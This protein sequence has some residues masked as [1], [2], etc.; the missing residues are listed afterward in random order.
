MSRIN[1]IAPSAPHPDNLLVVEKL[2]MVADLLEAQSASVFRVRAY[3]A[4]AEEV[5]GMA[6]PVADILHKGGRQALVDLPHIG[7]SIAAAIQE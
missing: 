4:A 6:S 7:T 1:H 2:S 3:R 5:A